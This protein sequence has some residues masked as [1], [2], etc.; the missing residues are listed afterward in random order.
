MTQRKKENAKNLSWCL[1][2]RSRGV[3]SLCNLQSRQTCKLIYS[4]Q[5]INQ[6]RHIRIWFL[7]DKRRPL[8]KSP[9]VLLHC[10]SALFFLSP[11][12][13]H[14]SDLSNSSRKKLWLLLWLWEALF[15]LLSFKFS[16]IGSLKLSLIGLSLNSTICFGNDVVVVSANEI[17][18]NKWRNIQWTKK[19][20]HD[21]D[22]EQ[23]ATKGK[24]KRKG[25]KVRRTAI[26]FF[27]YL[28]L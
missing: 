8:R 12:H 2:W 20:K 7:S 6:I 24:K 4:N 28:K 13:I 26:L 14:S 23:K 21:S 27:F 1:G 5:T 17:P 25:R 10:L 9:P 19:P 3:V 11:L 22:K 18:A 15:S 16:K